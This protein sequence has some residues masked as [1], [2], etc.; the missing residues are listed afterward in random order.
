M[1][2]PTLVAYLGSDHTDVNA[3]ESAGSFTWLSGDIFVV[4]GITEDNGQTFTGTPAGTGLTFSAIT[5]T[6][7]SN[8][9]ATGSSCKGYAWAATASSGN[10]GNI[11]ISGTAVGKYI[12]VWQYRASDG[13]GAATFTVSTAA[14]ANL[15]RTQANSAVAWASGDWG[16]ST[17]VTVTPSPAT[18]G[19]QREAFLHSGRYSGYAFDWADE[20]ATGTTAYGIGSWTASGSNVT[21]V[22]VEVKGAAGG[23]A[24]V[25]PDIA[26]QPLTHN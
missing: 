15:T 5:A 8:P 21:K 11:T 9:T 22:A 3:N 6:S 16:A 24:A 17:D 13:V 2:A 18:G 20:G 12:G 25:I 1:A 23:G 7:G 14:T 26:M 4:I 10:S 19:T